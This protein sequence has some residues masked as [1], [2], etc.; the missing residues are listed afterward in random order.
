MRHSAFPAAPASPARRRPLL[1]AVALLMLAAGS[2]QA[3][4]PNPT[5]PAPV[6][7]AL[8]ASG[9]VENL[10]TGQVFDAL[11]G[12]HY[13]ALGP[14]GNQ[15]LVSSATQPEAWLVDA[16]DG[17]RLATFA[18]G[19]T[20]QG[21]A[22][23]PDG[24]TGLAISAGAGTVTLLDLVARKPIAIVAVGN[25]PHNALFSADGKL[26]YVTLQGEGK[27]GV[28]DV[29]TRALTSTF[30]VPGLEHPHNLVFS[31]DG[32]TLWIRGFVGKVAAVDLATRKVLAVIPVG[33]GHAGIDVVPDSGLVVTGAVA[34]HFVD[35]IDPRTYK[36]VKRIDVGQ[37]PHGVRVSPD[38][39][40]IYAGVTAT[41]HVAVIDARTLKV[42][43][44]LPTR[45]KLPF[46][47]A[48][49]GQ[50]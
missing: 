9:A 5:V 12:A 49:A 22:I 19:P 26:A 11:P 25:N 43:A 46:W 42:V 31:A 1:T 38:G 8:Q 21:V 7:A 4:M 20:P 47:L 36:V 39:R 2:S 10:Q 29:R 48:V 30:P 33:L 45:G 13:L 50:R 28:I 17:K 16:H 27:A 34:D 6:Y 40:W 3:A 41:D 44:Q 18:I 35:V 23:S 32:R 14:R 37:G 24:R 15:L